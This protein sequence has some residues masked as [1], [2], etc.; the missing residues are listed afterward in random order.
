MKP[1]IELTSFVTFFAFWISVMV[2]G[3]LNGAIEARYFGHNW[4]SATISGVVSALLTL[5]F[6]VGWR[7][8]RLAENQSAP[9][10]SEARPVSR[11]T[12]RWSL[13]SGILSLAIAA[14]AIAQ[15]IERLTQ[16]Q[17]AFGFKAALFVFAMITAIAAVLQA[18]EAYAKWR[19]AGPQAQAS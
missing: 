8:V 6:F 13:I 17:V 15:W 9:P 11:K 10:P 2:V 3:A 5:L 7:Q 18:R 1:G 12:E 14:C 16:A 19:D 4:F